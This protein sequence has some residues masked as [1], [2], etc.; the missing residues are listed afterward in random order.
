MDRRWQSLTGVVGVGLT[1]VALA[2]PGPPPKASD[3]AAS[4]EAMLVHHR[5]AFVGGL[6]LASL[7]LM[8]LLWFIGVIAASLR[9]HEPAANSALSTV[10]LAGGLAGALLMFVGMVLFDGAAFRAAGLGDQTVV[11][12][13]VDTGNLLIET[14]KFGFAVLIFAT[15]ATRA[16]SGRLP[17]RLVAAGR[18]AGA[19]LILSALPTFLTDHGVGQIGGPIDLAGTVPALV[20]LGALSVCLARA[21]SVVPVAVPSDARV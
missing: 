20:W 6:L 4:M 19:L 14:S 9:R 17:E 2:L 10:A 21:G 16:T 5:G 1:T 11:R 8:A 18:A 15:C 13:S 3:S 7:G 12:A